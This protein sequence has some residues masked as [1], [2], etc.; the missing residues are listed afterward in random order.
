MTDTPPISTVTAPRMRSG[1]PSVPSGRNA[2]SNGPARVIH[3]VMLR[4]AD[5]CW[6]DH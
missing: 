4:A 6:C 5:A 2:M 1:Y 3:V